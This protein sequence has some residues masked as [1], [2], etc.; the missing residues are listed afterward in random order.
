[1][2][3]GNP[4]V[5][6]NEG[7]LGS[8]A[9]PPTG[10]GFHAIPTENIGN[11]EY[12][13]RFF[14]TFPTVWA[15]AYTFTCSLDASDRQALEEWASLFLLHYYGTAH[16]SFYE[17]DV[18]QDE[19][20]YD[21]D[22]WLALSGTYPL[23]GNGGG[24]QGVGLLAT[25][26][27]TVVGA[28]YP[29]VIFFPGRG[30]SVWADDVILKNLLTRAQ[31]L[32][33]ARCAALLLKT[34][35]DRREF[36]L[37]LLRVSALLPAKKYRD[38][39]RGFCA[40]TFGERIDYDAQKHGRLDPDPRQWTEIPGN[41]AP[42]G[43]E[44]LKRYPLRKQNK[45]GGYNYYL[46]VGMPAY[47]PWMTSSAEAGWPAPIQ[48]RKL[49]EK[50]IGVQFAGK[51]VV[52]EL[53]ENKDKI[54]LLK[55][56][57][58]PVAPYWC[59]V[60]RT[61]DTTKLRGLHRVELKDSVLTAD[62]V[63]VCLAPVTREFLGHFS[64][65]LKDSS[66]V[67]A[68]PAPDG[69]VNWV[70]QVPGSFGSL[71]V[72]WSAK[73]VGSLEMPKTTLALWPPKPSRRW[74]LYAAFGTG[75]KKT[76]GRWNLIDEAGWRG[77]SVEL[78]EAES[79]AEY[80]SILQRAEDVANQPRALLFTDNNDA[81]RG[82][83]FLADL[84]EHN[85]GEDVAT[86]SVDFGTSN[87]CVAYS[88]GAK[89]EILRFNLSPEMLW[90]A[91]P[92]SERLGFVPFNWSGEKG[93]Y[94]TILL[95]RLSDDTLPNL[96][97]DKIDVEH[98]FKVDVPGLHQRAEVNLF[99]GEGMDQVWRIH[100]N[101]KWD[102]DPKTPWRSLFLELTLLY[103]HAD[104]FFNKSAMVN[105]YVFTYPLAFSKGER[106]RYHVKAREAIEKVRKL[107]YRIEPRFA[108]F[109]YVD[110]VDESTAIAEFI[111]QGAGTTTMEVF[112]DVGGGTADLAIRHDRNFLVLD[113]LRVAGNAFF[114]IAD[115]NF[116]QGRSPKG[117]SQFKKQLN[118]LLLGHQD[119]E[120]VWPRPSGLKVEL[121]TFYSVAINEVS[122][123]EF[124]NREEAIL[125]DSK[126]SPVSYQKY[127]TLLLF[128][129]ILAYA[130][131]QACAAA[132]DGKL[133][134]PNGIKLILGGNAWGLMGF[135]GLP[136]EEQVLV[137]ESREILGLLKRFLTPSL[138]EAE[139]KYVEGLNIFSVDLLG[140]A[141]LSRAK[142]GVAIG[143]LR[144]DPNRR[145]R[146][147][148]TKPY[149]GI[150]LKRLQIND[151]NPVDVRWHER[152][153]FEKFREKF[154]PMDQINQAS[155]QGP[156]DMSKPLDPSLSAFSCLGNAGRRDQDIMPGETWSA[157]NSEIVSNIMYLQG[158]LADEAPINHF[159]SKIL[160]SDNPD[161]DFLDKLAEKNNNI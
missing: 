100:P 92:K 60:P 24:L 55:D 144:A 22:L 71:E 88:L 10:K 18:L 74:K 89:T 6:L 90:G 86:M 139:R 31:R 114:R 102:P 148:N 137:Q 142:V 120:L 27:Q 155:F 51:P 17:P 2:A 8:G 63:A 116:N 30:N 15:S 117:A 4:K 5:F 77:T 131:L 3:N 152:W 54:F 13:S 108:S 161:R 34:D 112:V 128:R 154:G 127:R 52:C 145:G 70:F 69:S 133:S 104:L 21:K 138:P 64:D 105:Q 134:L 39:L 28:F 129:H 44:F 19:R 16:L 135:G 143:A 38:L 156:S 101:L 151:F 157:I 91:K 132:V 96:S 119:V 14:E 81:E 53:T 35:A 121:N 159:V 122:S 61:T 75:L 113:S 20:A 25:D 146:A 78:D 59:K 123:Q 85:V 107:C 80:V 110:S 160:Y 115:R 149:T 111:R 140:E 7:I 23:S 56:L 95:S 150:T 118:R 103:A 109:E 46:L 124:R 36:H 32:S 49:D 47:S 130:L 93:F 62:D 42:K 41:K 72:R 79:S 37:H 66:E 82:V 12:D 76:S 125:S 141:D 48:Y 33:W 29:E 126:K 87:T 84:G 99:A 9:I 11:P 57:F 106:E 153:G 43:E 136:R 26:E 65:V 73:P 83:L 67:S 45:E 58:L 97:P 158:E 98:L 1:M 94:P 50:S 147:D 40:D 68:T